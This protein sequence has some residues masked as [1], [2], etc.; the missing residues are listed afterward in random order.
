MDDPE[1]LVELL[2]AYSPSG[3]EAPA[4]A[5][6][7]ALAQRLGY[8]VS[9]DVAGNGIARR[10]SGRPQILFLGHIDTVEGA[11]PVRREGT[12]IY[13]RG[14]CDAK[15]PLAAAL[16]AGRNA[17]T[18]GEVVVVAA[19]GEETDS[20][21]AR[22]LLEAFRPEYVIAGEPSGWDGLAVGY[23]GDLRL[24]ATF[25]GDRAHLSTPTASTADRAVEWIQ[26]LRQE[27]ARRTGSTPFRSLTFKVVSIATTMDG[28][29]ERV[30]AVVDLRIPPGTGAAAL[31][32]QLPR[33]GGPETIE[34]LVELDPYEGD[35]LDP[36]VAALSQGIRVAGG[37][38][39]LWRKT[40]T[41]DL[42]LVAPAWRVRGA[43]YGPGD[44]RLDHTDGEFLEVGDLDR[45]VRVLAHA[46]ETLAAGETMPTPRRSDEGA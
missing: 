25:L 45:A 10:G 31:L 12:R 11:L 4:V 46:F 32:A 3:H 35:R 15:G 26:G 2:E 27:V 43:A 41:S 37:R 40:G 16:L 38:P 36:V 33:D 1:V 8:S 23:K 18:R 21:G 34:P 44:S 29:A 24:K 14:A 42:N 7:R 5:R 30:E 9:S 39:T 22:A 20:R 17:P 28:G 13:G 19:V 6:F